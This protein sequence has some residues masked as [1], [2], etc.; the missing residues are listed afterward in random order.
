M[1][2][3]EIKSN[4]MSIKNQKM[5]RNEKRR[6]RERRGRQTII[7]RKNIV[8]RGKYKIKIEGDGGEQVRQGKVSNIKRMKKKGKREKVE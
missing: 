7:A 2:N 4:E 5:N 6:K 8:R 3:E 1:R